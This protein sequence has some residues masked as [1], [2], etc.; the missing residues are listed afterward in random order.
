LVHMDELIPCARR[1]LEFI[2]VQIQGKQVILI[3]D[4]LGL[5]QEG[6]AVEIPLYQ[7]MVLLDGKT[8]VRDLQM[9]LMRQ[10]GGMLVSSEEVRSILAHLDDS[11][12]L[13]SEKFKKAKDR[14]VSEF[15]S[16]KVRPSSH[17]GRAYPADPN[18]LK[19]KL[20]EILALEPESQRPDGKVLALVA[21][22]ID[23]SVGSRVYSKAYQ[24]LRD[25]S[26]KTVIVL[27]TGHQMAQDVF[28][29]SDKDFETPLGVAACDRPWVEKLR[30]AGGEVLARNDFAH[31]A[32][33]SIEFQVLFLQHILPK[34]SFA[35][36]PILCGNLQTTLSEYSRLAYREKA[37]RFLEAL[38][39]MLEPHGNETLLVA[40]VDL[41][42]I[43]PK[44]G[45]EMP[46]QYMKGQSEAHDKALLD[47]LAARN[48]DSFWK[49][50]GRVKDHYNVCGF[51]AL[52]CLLEVLPA[53]EG[54]LLR[55]EMWH[56]EATRSAVS[57]AAVAF[58]SS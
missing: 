35:I 34:A 4:H 39:E 36:V 2:P 58:T 5:V 29:V 33:H 42:H 57:Y 25:L 16:K 46:A 14:I 52:S 55:Y 41:S 13:E 12:L 11:F 9:T 28:A 43:G 49:E 54:H 53:C 17:S 26:P 47:S 24:N 56:E 7:F 22:H 44:F 32:E 50:S 51:A 31:R 6:K 19:R 18:E 15:V 48:A 10:R 37:G 45:H 30:A 27:G 3:R 23:L 1:D 8:T 20:D 21:P 40:G 38:K